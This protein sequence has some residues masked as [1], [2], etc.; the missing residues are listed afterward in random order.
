MRTFEVEMFPTMADP[1]AGTQPV[2]NKQLSEGSATPPPNFTM[3]KRQ[4]KVFRKRTS[5]VL[6][7]QKRRAK[8][9]GKTDFPLNLDQLRTLV[10]TALTKPCIYCGG[11]LTVQNFSL[12]HANPVS[13]GGSWEAHNLNV[14]CK[15][16]NETKGPLNQFEFFSIIA[17]LTPWDAEPRR[18]VLARLR[19]GARFMN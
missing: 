7:T 19:A 5:N 11:E 17:L 9:D 14:C 18:N 1:L 12:D 15:R 4:L 10:L 16:C 2:E 3:T 6:S 8:R 13:R